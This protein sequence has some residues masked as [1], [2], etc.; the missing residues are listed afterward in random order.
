[1]KIFM[2][3]DESESVD[4]IKEAL[5]GENYDF[6][7]SLDPIKG[8]EY[9]REHQK[10]I[11]ICLID[12]MMPYMDGIEVLDELRT[13][14]ESIKIYILTSSPEFC[15]PSVAIEHGIDGY[16]LK[17]N[18]EKKMFLAT[19]GSKQKYVS[20]LSQRTIDTRNYLKESSQKMKN[21]KI[22]FIN[23]R[24]ELVCA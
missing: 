6:D 2:I 24:P 13:F 3:D 15:R 7:Y 10:E 12:L 16:I 17:T 8:L 9:V 23:S 11:D 4:M 19:I 22:N 18:F 1:M 5:E 14:N 20:F 21:Q